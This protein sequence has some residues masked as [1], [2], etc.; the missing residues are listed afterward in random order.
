M[1]VARPPTQ[2]ESARQASLCILLDLGSSSGD[3]LLA[4]EDMAYRQIEDL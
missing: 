1:R 4:Q 2:D 3:R